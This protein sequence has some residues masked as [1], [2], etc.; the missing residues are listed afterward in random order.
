MCFAYVSAFSGFITF[1]NSVHFYNLKSTLKAPQ[2]LVVSDVSDLIM[3][4][5]DDLLANLQDSRVVV[6][7]LLDS[8]PSMFQVLVYILVPASLFCNVFSSL[9]SHL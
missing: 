9:L 7:T 6:D 8:L 5:P 2:M 4:S 1:D 3:P